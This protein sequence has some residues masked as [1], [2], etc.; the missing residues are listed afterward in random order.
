MKSLFRYL[1][2]PSRC[3]YLPGEVSR[4]E[5]ERVARLGA[6]EY[7]A[8]LLAGWRRFGR[9]LFRPRCPAC[10][11][12]RSLRVD[13]ARFRPDRSQR[14]ARKAAADLLRLEIGAPAVDPERLDLYDRY[15]DHQVLARAWPTHEPEDEDGFRDAFV[16]NPIPTEEWC[17]RLDGRLV[18]LGY[19]DALPVGYSAIYF[20]H[21]PD[22]R[23]LGLGNVNILALLAESARRGL[24]HLYL[25]FYVEGCRSLSYKARFRPCDLLGPD[26]RWNPFLD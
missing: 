19:V 12:C 22:H 18:G 16:D 17:Y 5:Y 3:S 10:T 11:A 1:S 13:V 8:L 2:V 7:T 9:N 23:D 20:V 6:E 4:L 14:R 24:P 26:G 25:G 21:D 15:H